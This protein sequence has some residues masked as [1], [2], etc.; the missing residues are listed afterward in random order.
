[1]IKTAQIMVIPFLSGDQTEAKLSE[2]KSD[3]M[4]S[5][6]KVVRLGLGGQSWL[7]RQYSDNQGGRCPRLVESDGMLYVL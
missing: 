7:E 3:W 1:M 4:R 2:Q 6:F 5:P